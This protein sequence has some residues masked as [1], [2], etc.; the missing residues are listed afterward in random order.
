MNRITLHAYAKL[1]LYL[2]VLNKRKDGYHNINTLFEKISL[3]DKLTLRLR[4]KDKKI[5]VA[6]D[7]ASLPKGAANIAYR[8]AKLL[9]D[10]LKIEQ[11]VDIKIIKRIPVGAG[12][13]GGS[14]D[15]AAVLLGLNKV[16]GLGLSREK[17]VGYAAMIGADV[18]FF[19]YNSSFAVASGR[20]D[21]IIPL[22]PKKK[23]RLWHI[24]VVPKVEVLTAAVYKEW[25][26][27]KTFK[28]TIPK[29]DIKILVSGLKRSSPFLASYALFNALEAVTVRLYPEVIRVKEK[30]SQLGL[31]AI[32]MSG[33][34]PAVFGIV[35]SRKEAGVLY[36][37][38]KG[39]R[40]WQV[41]AVQTR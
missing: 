28:L 8:S 22:R 20:G 35:S 37:Q 21:K 7:K 36:K 24:L 26:R 11:G 12:L 10:S 33:S 34:G 32:L 14:S 41:F 5:T 17:L 23:R 25:D 13:G 6:S 38:L 19:I 1:N 18:P 9:Q 16:W 30:L 29:Y 40:R 3:S 39:N 2:A 27:L 31:E 4:P 15:A